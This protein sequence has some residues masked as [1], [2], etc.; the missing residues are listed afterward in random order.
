MG[1][2]WFLLLQVHLIGSPEKC[3]RYFLGVSKVHK[4]PEDPLTQIRDK[5]MTKFG[6]VD[7]M[8]AVLNGPGS[9]GILLN[10]TI[11]FSQGLLGLG[12]FLPAQYMH[13]LKAKMI[14]ATY[15][16]LYQ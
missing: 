8:L 1:A 6:R 11:V 2:L 16:R 5:S 14:L 3:I 12:K 7:N 4:I 13:T 15:V 9:T 10:F